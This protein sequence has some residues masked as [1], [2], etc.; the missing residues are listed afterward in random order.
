MQG[1][2]ARAQMYRNSGSGGTSAFDPTGTILITPWILK[3]IIA[4]GPH[5]N[6][7]LSYLAELTGLVLNIHALMLI[8][9]DFQSAQPKERPAQGM[10]ASF[11]ADL[12]K[13]VRA[14]SSALESAEL[15][16]DQRDAVAYRALKALIEDPKGAEPFVRKLQ[17]Q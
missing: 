7:V 8:V 15:P 2:E 14:F 11:H 13:T 17:A 9:K 10:D 5:I 4:A 16:P 1:G 3:A 12:R 6:N